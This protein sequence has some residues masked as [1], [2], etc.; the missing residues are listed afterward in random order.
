MSHFHGYGR[1][2][3]SMDQGILIDRAK[4]RDART[5]PRVG[6]FCEMPDGR[7]MRFSHDWGD[8]IQI[9]EGG[10][11]YLERN[12]GVSMSG[13]LE[14]GVSKLKIEDTGETRPGWFWFFHH[15][16]SMAHNGVDFQ[17]A[18]RVFRY[19]GGFVPYA[20]SFADKPMSGA[21]YN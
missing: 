8:D 13:G 4:A 11:Y 12:G 7:T 9:S 19:T 17:T 6:D 20:R 10:T 15:D 2:F 1:D 14:P 21:R 5:G 18:C 16:H 3:D